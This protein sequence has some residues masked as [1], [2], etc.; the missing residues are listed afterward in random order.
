VFLFRSDS[1]RDT[2]GFISGNACSGIDIGIRH[3]DSRFFFAVMSDLI[4]YSN[5]V[6]SQSSNRLRAL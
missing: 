2:S 1:D 4:K 3:R 5:G 6:L